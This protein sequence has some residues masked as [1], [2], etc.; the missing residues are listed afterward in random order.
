[1]LDKYSLSVSSLFGL[2]STGFQPVRFQPLRFQPLRTGETPMLPE[3]VSV[4]DRRLHRRLQR[5]LRAGSVS[6]PTRAAEQASTSKPQ[7]RHKRGSRYRAGLP[8][9]P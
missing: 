1:L 8:E 4:M 7:H 6:K 2:G 3:R 9:I 5:I